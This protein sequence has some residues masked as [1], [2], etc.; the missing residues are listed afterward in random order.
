M[1]NIKKFLANKNTVTVVGVFLAVIALYV[2]YMQNKQLVQVN[3]L[4]QIW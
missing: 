3:K 2:G 4:L 1:G